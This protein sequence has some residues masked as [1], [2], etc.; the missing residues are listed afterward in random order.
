MHLA[1]PPLDA[2]DLLEGLVRSKGRRWQ[3]DAPLKTSQRGPACGKWDKRNRRGDKFYCVICS[4]PDHADFK[5]A[6]TLELHGLAGVYG[7]SKL[8]F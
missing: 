6:K 3:G 1:P 4:Y 5:A 2:V 8:D 7:A